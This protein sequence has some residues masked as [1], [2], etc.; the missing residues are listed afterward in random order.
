MDYVF[1]AALVPLVLF[2]FLA[3]CDTG[4]LKLLIPVVPCLMEAPWLA[5][6]LNMLAYVPHW[7]PIVKDFTIDL[8]WLEPSGFAFTAFNPMTA[9]RCVLL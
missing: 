8:S 4:Q 2:K 6:V 1:P 9:Q 3:E 7:C 5:T